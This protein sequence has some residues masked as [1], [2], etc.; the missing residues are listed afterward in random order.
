MVQRDRASDLLPEYEPSVRFPS[1]GPECVIGVDI[2]GTKIAAA[3][4][5]PTGRIV[6]KQSVSSPAGDRDA[7]VDAILKIV[8]SAIDMARSEGFEV[9]GCG[10]GAAGFILHAEGVLLESPNIAWSMVPLER[11]VRDATGLPSFLDNDANAAAAGE[12][13][14][15]ACQGVDDFVYL[16]L[17]TGVGGGLFVNGKLY[18][19]ARGTAAELGHMTIDPHGPLCGCGRRGCLEAMASGTALEREAARF[20][21]QDKGSALLSMTG[22]D[23]SAITGEIV[24]EAAAAGDT[25]ALEAFHLIAYHLGLGIVNLIHAF[26]PSMVVLGGGMARS[27]QF[28]LEEVRHA[29]AAHGIGI[30]VEGAEIVLSELG[31]DAGLIGAGA[32]AWEGIGGPA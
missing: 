18:R 15:G 31:A 14:R 20:A 10:I 21:A 30:L 1:E 27:G 9:L 23:L 19:G 22:G 25:A 4:I 13:F 2:G 28:L 3:A 24:S 6:L 11:L 8:R 7:M 5:D 32:I 16:T 17:G 12:H 29:V 26:D